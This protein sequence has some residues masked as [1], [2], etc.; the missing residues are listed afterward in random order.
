MPGG[1][2]ETEH[3]RICAHMLAVGYD[4]FTGSCMLLHVEYHLGRREWVHL[5]CMLLLLLDLYR[6]TWRS[7]PRR[8]RRFSLSSL[9]FF[10]TAAWNNL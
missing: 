10:C 1:V 8:T 7:P 9:A 3:R 6:E 4:V 2:A 5:A